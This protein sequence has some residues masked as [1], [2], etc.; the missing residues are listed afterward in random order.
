RH[1][2]DKERDIVS[3]NFDNRVRRRPTIGRDLRIIDAQQVATS[4]AARA[5]TPYRERRATQISWT[6]GSDV[7]C[8]NARVK[9]WNEAAYERT[10]RSINTAHRQILGGAHMCCFLGFDRVC[11]LAAPSSAHTWRKQ[12]MGISVEGASAF[13]LN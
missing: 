11:Q 13:R 5:E 12:V 9:L 10:M 8:R 3:D 7:I 4:F 6:P 1:R 2:V